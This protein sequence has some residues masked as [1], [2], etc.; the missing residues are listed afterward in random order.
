MPSL[1][2]NEIDTRSLLQVSLFPQKSVHF[3]IPEGGVIP[4][5]KNALI[6]LTIIN[7]LFCVFLFFPLSYFVAIMRHFIV[8]RVTS[9]VRSLG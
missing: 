4:L 5:G 6:E 1:D 8:A 2:E 9:P 3:P 7:S